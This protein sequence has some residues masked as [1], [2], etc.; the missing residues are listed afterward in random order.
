MKQYLPLEM[1][2]L[3]SPEIDVLT[4][5]VVNSNGVYDADGES[6]MDWGEVAY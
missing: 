1:S 4:Q 5:S 2:I 6:G 3:W